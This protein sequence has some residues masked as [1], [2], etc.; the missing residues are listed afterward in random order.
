MPRGNVN[1]QDV[2]PKTGTVDTTAAS[3]RTE[4][5][6]GM[7]FEHKPLHF[8]ALDEQRAQFFNNNVLNIEGALQI[9]YRGVHADVGGFVYPKK[10]NSFGDFS[11][12]DAVMAAGLIGINFHQATLDA[13][14]NP[15]NWKAIPT[16]NSSIIYNDNE[17]RAFPSDMYLHWSVGSFGKHTTPY[18]AVGN[19]K[20]IGW[21]EWY[22]WAGK[23]AP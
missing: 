9:G 6:K 21:R 22:N 3:Y 11:R 19:R 13:A 12:N 4:L 15:I 10:A 14:R 7:K 1:C 16:E 2:T 8:I 5:P 23:Y 18:N 20:S 17:T